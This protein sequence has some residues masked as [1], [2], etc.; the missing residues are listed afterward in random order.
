MKKLVLFS[1]VCALF[2]ASCGN[3]STE[4]KAL[5]AQ[6]DS[7]MLVNARATAELDDMLSLLNEVEDN[8]QSI[9]AAENYLSVQST[10]GGELTPSTRERITS[11]MKLITETLNKNK[12]QIAKL[13]G[14]LKSS[15]I[16]SAQLKKTI[17]RMH[18]ELNEKTAALVALQNE[19]SL[20]D[21]Q[22][23]ELSESITTLSTDVQNLRS[24][25]KEQKDQIV[26][27][28]TVY[29]CF[30]TSKELKDQKILDK[31]AL[32]TNFNKDYFIRVKDA[33]KL[34]EVPLSAKKAKLITKHPNGSYEFAKDGS[35]ILTLRILDAKNFWSLGKYLVVEVD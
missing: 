23:A 19:L 33:T 9:K 18:T 5:Q 12:E 25:T 15:G 22:I 3:N 13:E 31:G 1:A 2:L 27:L 7:L 24:E 14:R 26:T 32:G 16:Q 11:D 28:S 17:E 10:T 6:N 21:Q 8:F 4:Y 29:Y 30:G 35:G 34:T 20:K